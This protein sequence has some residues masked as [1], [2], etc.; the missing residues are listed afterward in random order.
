MVLVASGVLT[1]GFPPG[2]AKAEVLYTLETNCSLRGE[3][4]VACQVQAVDEAGATLYRHTI[5]STT[6]TLRISDQPARLSLWDATSNSWK[7]LRNAAVRFSTNTLCLNDA[8]LCVVNPNYLNSLLEER[9]DFRGRDLVRARFD[10][11]GR[12]DLLCYDT[13]CDVLTQKQEVR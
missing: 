6:H 1:L 5:G 7:P 2:Q 11:S 13:G 3:A 4:P 10:A 8:Q 12:I 9:L